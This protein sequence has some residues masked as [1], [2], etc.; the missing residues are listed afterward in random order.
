M[1]KPTDNPTANNHV[2]SSAK[3]SMTAPTKLPVVPP[4]GARFSAG[5]LRVGRR[6]PL[7]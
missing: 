5:A 7:G 3:E 1:V 4:S 6:K 2:V